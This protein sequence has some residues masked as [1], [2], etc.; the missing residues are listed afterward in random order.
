MSIYYVIWSTWKEEAVKTPWEFWIM[1]T[2]D[3]LKPRKNSGKY[4]II[5]K[6][7]VAQAFENLNSQLLDNIE[8]NYVE[9]YKIVSFVESESETSV[10][11]EIKKIFTDAEFEKIAEVDEYTKSRIIDLFDQTIKKGKE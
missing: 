11:D 6:D 4:D 5:D 1:S 3:K 9:G 10:T 2:A 7:Q 8:K